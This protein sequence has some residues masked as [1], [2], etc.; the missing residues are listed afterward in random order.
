MDLIMGKKRV[1]TSVII[2]AFACLF[3]SCKE[4]PVASVLGEI[5]GAAVST[6]LDGTV[7]KV[8]QLKIYL[9]DAGAKPDTVNIADNQKLIIDSA[10][11]DTDGNYK[12]RNLKEGKYAVSP[13]TGSSSIM[14]YKEPSSPDPA[15]IEI[16]SQKQAYAINF[17]VIYPSEDYPAD[18]TPFE[19][20]VVFKNLKWGVY[21]MKIQRYEYFCFI[22]LLLTTY[23]Q[24]EL[25]DEVAFSKAF[26]YKWQYGYT[27]IVYTLTNKFRFTIKQLGENPV[28]FDYDLTLSNCPASATFE[29]D[30]E[31]KTFT[32]IE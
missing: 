26:N 14:V 19:F 31:A 5:K 3:T 11:T 24:I 29:Y 12:F 7:T 20:N 17:S 13:Y 10:F 1:L 4:N 21:E 8:P 9:L 6:A 22:P 32:R 23:L 28:S 2:L 25:G 15:N 30:Y 16:N 18:T 27:S